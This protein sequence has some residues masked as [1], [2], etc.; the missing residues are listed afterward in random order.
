MSFPNATL[1]AG[2]LG[3]RVRRRKHDRLHREPAYFPPLAPVYAED[4]VYSGTEKSRFI[5]SVMNIGY[6]ARNWFSHSF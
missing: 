2:Q 6:E 3:H 5:I 4:Y 1:S